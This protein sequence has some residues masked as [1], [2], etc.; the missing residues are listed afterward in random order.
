VLSVRY[1]LNLCGLIFVEMG[2]AVAQAVISPPFTAEA[3]AP[4]QISPCEICV[5][6]SGAGT[7][8]SP[9]T[10]VFP[11]I[12]IPAMFCTHLHLYVA[13]IIRTNW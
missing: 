5:E 2:C 6:H 11:V 8:F 10:P 3:R 13:L 12:V 9:S 7:G 4:S 1:E